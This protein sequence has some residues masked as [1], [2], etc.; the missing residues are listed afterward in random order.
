MADILIRRVSEETKALLKKR[1]ER[2]GVSLEADLREALDRIALEV[3]DSPD[4][5]TPFGQWLVSISR[6]GADLDD[7]IA[8]LRE[9]PLREVDL[10]E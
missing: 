7:A 2:R 10:S 3:A 5:V 8:S 9:A 6:P 1:A 4:E